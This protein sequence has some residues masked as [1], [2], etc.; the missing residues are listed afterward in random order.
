MQKTLILPYFANTSLIREATVS[1][2]SRVRI[3]EEV[4]SHV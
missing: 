1:Q 4:Y 3:L 2:I